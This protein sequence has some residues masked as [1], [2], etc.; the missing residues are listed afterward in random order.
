MPWGVFSAISVNSGGDVWTKRHRDSKNWATTFCAIVA[1]GKFDFTKSA[2]LYCEFNGV[3]YRI[4]LPPGIPIF[5]PS[6]LITHWNSKIVGPNEYRGSIVYWLSGALV[7]YM[8]LNGR[9][10]GDLEGEEKR[11]YH[12]GAQARLAKALTLWSDSVD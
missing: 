9:K 4:E 2:F 11:A 7:R 5:I 1:F 12:K 10:V 3:V 8:E 6:A